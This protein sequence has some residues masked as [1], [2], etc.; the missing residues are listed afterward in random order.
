VEVWNGAL[1]VHT[2]YSDGSGDVATV[3]AAAKSARLRFVLLTDHDTLAPRQDVGD[4]WHDGVLVGFGVEVSPPENHFLAFG[5]SEVPDRRQPPEAYVAATNAQGGF[6]FAAHPH[7]RGSPL[8]RLPPYRWTASYDGVTGIELFN[9]MSAFVAEAQRLPG[10]LAALAWPTRRIAGPDPETLALWDRLLALRPTPMVMGIDAHA[11]RLG[12]LTVFPYERL[13]AA[14]QMFLYVPRPP[15][16]DASD[17]ALVYDALRTG[18]GFGARTD[19]G[20]PEGFHFEVDGALPGDEIRWTPG[21]TAHLLTPPGGEGRLLQSGRVL[22]RGRK[23][24]AARLEGPGPVRAEVW[25]G[26]QGWVFAN[27]VYVTPPT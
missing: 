18:R 24:L 7:D 27:P 10:A 8:L 1:H 14:L 2:T 16:F 11:Y 23:D 15:A 9:Y 26:R 20:L 17:L 19:L 6:G 25:R 12:P 21:L 5:V 4:G 22:A 13:F 3:V